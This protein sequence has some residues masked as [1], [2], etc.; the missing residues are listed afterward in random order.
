MARFSS[1]EGHASRRA[2]V[3]EAIGSIDPKLA[4]AGTHECP[5]R[6]LAIAIASGVLTAIE[7]AGYRLAIDRTVL[8]VDGRPEGLP[9]EPPRRR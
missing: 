3:I 6:Q 2:A 7:E 8:A 5:G 9:L 4:E 1:E